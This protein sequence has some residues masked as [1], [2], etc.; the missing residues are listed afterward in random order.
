[1]KSL[2]SFGN[3]C[4]DSTAVIKKGRDPHPIHHA[5]TPR[6]EELTH[7]KSQVILTVDFLKIALIYNPIFKIDF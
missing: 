5:L 4:P 3:N 1:M 7:L 6:D 2:K